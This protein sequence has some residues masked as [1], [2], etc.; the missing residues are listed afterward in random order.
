MALGGWNTEVDGKETPNAGAAGGDGT[1]GGMAGDRRL[2]NQ[3]AKKGCYF[4]L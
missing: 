4:L 1:T 3:P 2:G